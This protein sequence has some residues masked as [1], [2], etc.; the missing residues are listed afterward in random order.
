MTRILGAV[1]AGGRSSRFG[2][3][4]A[5]ALWQGR[6][7][8]DWA[9]DAIAPHVE[10]VIV[11]GREDG[12]PD[13]PAG[14]LGPLAGLNAA[15][16]FARAR[17][18][19]AVLSLACDTPVVDRDLLERLCR[20]DGAAYVEDGP[21]IGLW[22]A[23]RADALDELLVGQDRSM[24]AWIARIGATPIPFDGRIA[25]INRPEDLAALRIR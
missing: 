15:L 13:R 7:L 24:R 16:H 19:D 9:I 2:S 14:G 22:P 4:K 10:T 1:L 3:D 17:G 8:L 25:N 21:V 6:P 5:L 12:L 11:C 18:F 23:D 20:A